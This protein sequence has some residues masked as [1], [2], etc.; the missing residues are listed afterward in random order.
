MTD[1]A[2]MKDEITSASTNELWD[3]IRRTLLNTEEATIRYV[4]ARYE[5]NKRGFRI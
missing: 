3:I 2:A 5:L 1:F 4:Y